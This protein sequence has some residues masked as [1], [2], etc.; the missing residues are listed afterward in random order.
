MQG[1]KMTQEGDNVQAALRRPASEAVAWLKSAFKPTQ[2][3]ALLVSLQEALRQ[4]AQTGD[5]SSCVQQLLVEMKRAGLQSSYSTTLLSAL[6]QAKVALDTAALL[7]WLCQSLHLID[8]KA[9]SL[10]CKGL[11]SEEIQRAKAGRELLKAAVQQWHSNHRSEAVHFTRLTGLQREF[12]AATAPLLV[13][14]NN[15]E[16]VL[17]EELVKGSA[18][19]VATLVPLLNKGEMLKVAGR[20]IRQYK[21]EKERFSD[22]CTRIKRNAVYYFVNNGDLALWRLAEILESDREMLGMLVNLMLLSPKGPIRQLAGELFQQSPS[23]LSALSPKARK[24]LKS[25]RLSGS[26]LPIDDF[27]PEDPTALRYPLDPATVVLVSCMEDLAKA[28]L[29]SSDV[30]GFDCEWLP[31]LISINDS[32]VALFQIAT[33]SGAFL[34]D[35]LKL[36]DSSLL[37]SKLLTLFANPHIVKVGMSFDGDLRKLRESCPSLVCFQVPTNQGSVTAYAD[38]GTLN[39]QTFKGSGGL[40]DIAQ[41]FLSRP[42]CKA[43]QR[44]GWDKRPLRKRQL[45]YAALDAYVEILLWD[46]MVEVRSEEQPS[47]LSLVTEL[48]V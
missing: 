7:A 46:R 6:N 19:L 41:R 12:L 13:L 39:R 23:L 30:V 3:P 31:P 34:L 33:R 29:E 11:L 4:L 45:H 5:V 47:L 27:G 43:E 10:L 37:D 22:I 1:A 2:F 48:R 21:L 26:F 35:M 25:L 16:W 15:D 42:L 40:K 20:L 8:P 32:P 9:V 38:L 44:S 18:D 17:A 28:D 24:S 14:V 36:H